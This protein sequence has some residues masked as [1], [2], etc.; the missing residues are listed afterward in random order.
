MKLISASSYVIF[1]KDKIELT[2]NLGKVKKCISKKHI[3]SIK[4]YELK[5]LLPTESLS[6][7]P[8]TFENLDTTKSTIGTIIIYINKDEK[9]QDTKSENAIFLHN[10]PNAVSWIRKYYKDFIVNE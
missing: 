4:S 8:I 6:F 2:T 1:Y 10:N 3:P 9:L 5:K 7:I